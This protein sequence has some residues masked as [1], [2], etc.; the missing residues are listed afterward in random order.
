M[1]LSLSLILLLGF[2]AG[3]ICKQIK[4]PP[5]IGML[6][7]GIIIGPSVL[8]IIDKSLLA[9]ASELRSIAL[10][11]IL[12]RAGLKLKTTDL[13][14]IGRPAVLISFVPATFELLAVVIFAPL[15]I[16]GIKPLDAAMMGSVLA[17]VSPAVII[18]TMI[19]IMS[20]KYGV[21]KRIPHLILAGSSVD[22]IY[23]IVL[24]YALLNFSLGNSMTAWD[25]IKVPLSII[26]GVGLGLILGY[27]IVKLF[28]WIQLPNIIQLIIVLGI[29][30][31]LYGLEHTFEKYF[32][33][34][35][36]LAVISLALMIQ[37]LNPK[38]AAIMEKSYS[39]IW[40]VFEIILFVL[41]GA[42]TDLQSLN[43]SGLMLTLVIVIALIFRGIG[44]MLALIKTGLTVKEKIFC[45]ISFI[46]KATV[47]AAIGGIALANGLSSGTSILSL[48]VLSILITAPLGS[49]LIELTYKKLLT[50]NDDYILEKV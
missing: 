20:E 35:A 2:L 15:L 7:V 33:V 26:L 42:A 19:K 36:L 9:I 5:L 38:E 23:V 22:D 10:I 37:K 29:S 6:G 4:L 28:K 12:T 47:Q 30:F 39:N 16:E 21:K 11:V 45:I 14:A 50:K 3:F 34:S 1:I 8:N 18:P 41:V 17:A 25:I 27:I 32:P 46:P 49:I 13:R 48:A 44:V 43:K 24:F 40:Q 31:G